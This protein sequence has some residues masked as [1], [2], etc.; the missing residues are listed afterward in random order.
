MRLFIRWNKD[1]CRCECL[2]IKE[3]NDNSSWNV[4][5][6][7]CEFKKAVK[8]IVE[9]EEFGILNTLFLLKIEK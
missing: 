6:C 9:E 7:R 4:V 1:K 8:L 2:Q 5:N 3:C